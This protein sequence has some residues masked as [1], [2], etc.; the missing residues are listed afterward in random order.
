[1]HDAETNP[2]GDAGVDG[3]AASLEDAKGWPAATAWRVP[4]ASGRVARAEAAGP[5]GA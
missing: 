3:V 1:V 4:S 2:G 5:I